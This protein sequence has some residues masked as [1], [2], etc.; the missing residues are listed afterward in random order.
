MRC[1][2]VC[3]T[4]CTP[5]HTITHSNRLSHTQTDSHT[6]KQTQIW[7][8]RHRDTDTHPN[9][10]SHRHT[11]A[12]TH[13][14]AQFI[15]RVSEVHWDQHVSLEVKNHMHADKHSCMLRVCVCVCVCVCLAVCLSHF[16]AVIPDSGDAGTTANQTNILAVNTGK[17]DINN[18]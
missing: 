2:C 13:G 10:Q 7:T 1:V 9:R 12:H 3:L 5:K 11:H 16:S 4:G 18:P 17:K 15:I 14:G 6:L 8:D